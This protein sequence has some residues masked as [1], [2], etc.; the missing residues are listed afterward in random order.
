MLD[1]FDDFCQDAGILNDQFTT[2]EISSV[3]CKSMLT[4]VDEV[5]SNHNCRASFTEF[6]EMVCRAANEGSY[7]PPPQKGEDGE[8]IEMCVE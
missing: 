4:S 6:L 1:E 3:F 8:D 2:P 7:P 5:I